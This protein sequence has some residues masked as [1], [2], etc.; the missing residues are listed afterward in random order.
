MTIF[1]IEDDDLFT[2]KLK[3]ELES[4]RVDDVHCF[5][6]AERAMGQMNLSPDVVFL[7]HYLGG[8]NGI[9]I[10]PLIL[11]KLPDCKII[12]MSSQQDINVVEQA[13]STGAYKYVIKND[14]FSV[15]VS[16]VIHE[17]EEIKPASLLNKLG[18]KFI[19]CKKRETPLVFI[20]DDDE[21]FGFI[22]QYR[23]DDLKKFVIE[24]FVDGTKA[25]NNAE[26]KPDVLI[27]DY[28]LKKM[29]GSVVLEKY[30]QISPDT[31]VI[32][33]SSQENIDVAIGLMNNGADAYVVKGE[34][35]INKLEIAINKVLD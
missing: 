6:S 19:K 14:E 31:K 26:K 27:L 34:D 10:I 32:I 23:I 29:K 35:V 30:R 16:K 17:I 8:I 20:V 7:D 13:L 1:I 5:S 11:D 12:C 24:T 4:T 9:E 21:T 33:V 28:H 22:I 3:F 2:R 18:R 15:N 25:I